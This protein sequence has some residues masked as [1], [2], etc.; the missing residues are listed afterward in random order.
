MFSRAAAVNVSV[1]HRKSNF[2]LC[3]ITVKS[4][5]YMNGY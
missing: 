1:P 3:E 4:C 2:E 5:D